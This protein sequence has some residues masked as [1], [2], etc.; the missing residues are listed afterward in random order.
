MPDSFF[1]YDLETSGISSSRDRIMQFGGQRTDLN[2]KNTG[3]PINISIKLSDDVLPSTEAILLSGISPIKSNATGMSE[4][5]FCELFNSQIATAGTI[6]TGF[7]NVRF[8][9]EF[10]RYLNYRNFY[11]AFSWHWQDGSSRWDLLDVVRMTRALR[12]EGINWPLSE[13]NKPTNKL[14]QLTMHN[15]LKHT[16]A[17]DALSDAL[18]TKEVAMLLKSK[19]P[20]LFNYLR[21]LRQKAALVKLLNNNQCLVYTS[22]HYS[23]EV[24]HTTVVYVLSF[25]SELG[26]ALVFDLR[27]DASSFL[28]LSIDELAK[29]WEYDPNHLKA[30]LPV[31]TMKLNR[32][33]AV[34][35]L[36]VLDKLS[37]DRLN[38]NMP[39]IEASKRLISLRKD[40]FVDKLKKAAKKLDK[41]RDERRKSEPRVPAV[42]ERLYDEFIPKTDSSRFKLARERAKLAEDFKMSFED[43]RLDSLYELYRARNYPDSL[44]QDEKLAWHNHVKQALLAGSPSKNELFTESLKLLKQAYLK[45]KHKLNLLIDLENYAKTIVSGYETDLPV[46]A[47]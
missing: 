15:Q 35:P 33:P 14:E 9:D 7:N 38:L 22:S 34:A 25:D 26:S 37:I 23:F 45:D 3:K 13:D 32:C 43:R 29:L 31:K 10:I 47:A 40:E 18:A 28:D 24:L 42:D 17:H 30:R 2:L 27:A 44:S 16:N 46:K 19:Q 8:D 1:F 4:A 5:E 41:T 39:A 11:D 12:P 6:F 21:S 20:K 36:G